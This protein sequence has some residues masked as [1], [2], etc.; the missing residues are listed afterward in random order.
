MNT[1]TLLQLG[2]MA[3]AFLGAQACSE[4]S[5]RSPRPPDRIPE[6]VNVRA[7]QVEIGIVNGT[8]RK[9]VSVERFSISRFPTTVREY[10]DCVHAGACSA[11][12]R[13]AGD[14]ASDQR[15]VGSR[16]YTAESGERDGFPVTCTDAN[17]AATFCKW[18]G[19]RLPAIEEWMHAA[20]GPKVQR[21]SWGSDPI[22]CV[23]HHF[24]IARLGTET[25]CPGGACKI[26]EIL[27]VGHHAGGKSPHGVEDVLLAPA[28]LVGFSEN[29]A[30][31]ACRKS[32]LGCAVSTL[33][34]ASIDA[35]IPITEANQT[36]NGTP[37][38]AFRC[39]WDDE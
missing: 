29:A 15:G 18:V 11:P 2:T 36:S 25:C 17:Q 10:R 9:I 22:T 20:R 24:A 8:I 21:Y 7:D 23:R 35:L 14:C 26:S 4:E 1:R 28:E 32:K 39:A 12:A 27:G 16:T 3:T 19:G 33:E 37:V 5:G 38:W 6:S 31:P 13:T 34:A 30:M